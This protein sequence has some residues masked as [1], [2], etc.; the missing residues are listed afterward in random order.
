MTTP[1]IR[2]PELFDEAWDSVIIASYGADLEFFERILLRQLSGTRNRV[3][4]ADGRQVTQTLAE[5]DSRT[6]LRQVNRTYVLAPM[7]ASG[8]AHAKLIM[9]LSEDRGLLA[10]GSGNLGMNGYAS[11]GECFSRYRWSEDDQDQLG[12]FLAAR[13]FID[14]ICEQRLVDP[15]VGEFVRQAWEGAPWLFGKT[16]HGDSRVRHN[17]ERALLDQFVE[18]VGGRTVDELVVHAP[19]Y[20]RNC[21]ALAR[22]VQR[23]SPRTLK[24]LLQERLTSV[25]PERL[26][27]VL[28]EAPGRVDVRSVKAVVK[29]TFLHAKFLIARCE[30]IAVCLQGSANLSSPALL[31]THPDGNIELA[32]LLVGDRSN[33]DHLITC[34]VVSPDSVDDISQLGL[35]IVSDGDDDDETPLRC[36]V[37]DLTWVAPRLTGVFDREIRV[38]PQLVIDEEPVVEVAWEMSE[39]SVGKTRFAVTLGEKPAAALSQ[40]AAVCFVFE[41]GEESL[42][43]FPYHPNVLMALASGQRRTD[44]LK[45]AGDFELDDEEL[46]ELLAQLDQA[47]VVDGRSIWRMLKR[48][49][50]DQSADETSA[51][52]A[53]DDLDWDAIQSHPKLAQY[54]NWDQHSSTNPT[55]LGMLLTSIAKRF[56]ATVQRRHKG[57]PEPD[58]PDSP[59]DPLDDLA[60]VIDAE[61]EE[62]A[63]KD[64]LTRD[65]RRTSA[66]SRVR[67]QFHSFVQRFVNGL[68]DEAFVRH[69][70]PSVL[71]PSYVI[72]NHLCWKL[73]QIDLADP[74]RLTRLQTTLWR[75]FWG[76]K[77]EPGYFATLSTGEQEAAL[78]ILDHHHSE[79]VLLCSIFQAYKHTQHEKDH[80]AMIEVRDAWRTIVL[81]PLFQP[82][83]TAVDQAATQIQ[84]ECKSASQLIKAA[85]PPRGPCSRNRTARHHRQRPRMPAAT[86]N[87]E[88]QKGD[89]ELPRFPGCEHLHH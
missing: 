9:L 39:P 71:V 33:F 10:V 5:P 87:R 56:E 42:P 88:V 26:S 89:P 32:N 2:I 29:G 84:H 13:G 23:T 54:R 63:E 78:D 75:F 46:E 68:T 27:V 60:K 16:Q 69:V 22:L 20:D 18:A 76:D 21:Q 45:R 72:F 65:R 44:L 40:V 24:V 58:G 17:L 28:A 48:K 81:Q 47:L 41:T 30:N 51:S 34:L 66:R 11:G 61:D 53:Y 8:A 49:V 55:A 79:A 15:F 4:F 25:D 74:L 6:Q 14:Q 3:V 83:E 62:G 50:P 82:T 19:F 43:T 31:R 12:E 86:S 52:I 1:R 37:E 59:S 73:I 57:G 70:G 35:G 67:R 77:N 85:G 36:T 64:E 38:P 7:R 80:R